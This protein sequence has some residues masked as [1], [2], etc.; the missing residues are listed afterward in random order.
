MVIKPFSLIA[1]PR[2]GNAWN[3]C[4]YGLIFVIVVINIPGVKLALGMVTY[5]TLDFLTWCFHF[6]TG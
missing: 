1:H 2:P 3:L 4:R 6:P 5:G